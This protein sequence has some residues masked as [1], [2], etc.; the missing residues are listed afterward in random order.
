MEP[1][2]L[3]THSQVPAT[4]PDPEPAYSSPCLHILFP[5]DPF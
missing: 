1:E 5:E 2:G 4:C 3:L